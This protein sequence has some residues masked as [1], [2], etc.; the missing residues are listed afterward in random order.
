M[1]EAHSAGV[2]HDSD[3]ALQIGRV[4]HCPHDRPLPVPFRFVSAAQ[5][6]ASVEAA[7][8]RALEAAHQLEE[9]RTSA[10]TTTER[11]AALE[12][13]LADSLHRETVDGVKKHV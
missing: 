1:P 11:C 7:E 13:Q 3:C 9:A 8:A 10:R 4:S 5:L 12:A 2:H 6:R